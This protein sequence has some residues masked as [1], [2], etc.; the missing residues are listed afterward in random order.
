[1]PPVSIPPKRNA[2]G[3][4][5]RG[6][7][8]PK[9]AATMPLNPAFWVNAVAPPS[10]MSR[11]DSLPKTRIAP[12]TPAQA[13]ENAR[14]CTMLRFTGMPAYFDASGLW[15]TARSRT[16]SELRKSR[17]YPRT[18]TR[19]AIGTPMWSRVPPGRSGRCEFGVS[20]SVCW[21]LIAPSSIRRS[22]SRKLRS[23]AATM[24]S[25]IVDRISLTPA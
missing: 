2:A 13:P 4:V 15:P 1:M 9:S 12:A 25:M 20:R 7:N 16:P 11:C 8:A 19:I 3:I 10:P 17:T 21:I 14:A 23:C 5:D 18:A 6:C 22:C 24:F